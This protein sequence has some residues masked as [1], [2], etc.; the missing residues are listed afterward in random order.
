MSVTVPW[1]FVRHQ[2]PNIVGM[3]GAGIRSALPRLGGGEVETPSAPVTRR[4]G[5]FSPALI[6]AYAAWAGAP[7]DRYDGVLPPHFFAYWGLG[8]VSELTGR[9]PY[10]LLSA[11]NQGCRIATRTLLPADEPIQV[12]GRLTDVSDDGRRIRIASQLEAGTRST[13]RAQ[14]IEVVAAVP[15]RQPGP[16]RADRPRDPEPAFDTVG[17]W[18]ASASDGLNFALLTG[19]FNPLHTLTPVG[20]RTRYRSCILHGF[21]ILA[22]TYETIRNAGIDI[23]EFE[24]RYV[25]PVPL[26]SAD[27][28]VQVAREPD[29]D[30]RRAIRLRG[31]DDTL[32]LAGHLNVTLT[33][34]D[35]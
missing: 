15:R 5:P 19:D 11:V 25:K 13:P 9:A 22:R 10:N 32:H 20:R 6:E 26:P 3:F 29:A 31:A 8:L 23:A 18:S 35:A 4:M 30:G 27:L 14:D 21:G 28:A 2:A 1:T 7:P 16:R 24:V 12:R 33:G 34:A 17:H